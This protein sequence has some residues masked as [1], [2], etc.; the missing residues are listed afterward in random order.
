[1]IFNARTLTTLAMFVLFAGACLMA[2]QLPQ[3]AAFMPLLIGVPGTLLCA[4][5]LVIDVIRVRRDGSE[6]R[7]AETADDNSGQSETAAFLWLGLFSVALIGFGFVVGG[8]LIV[9]AFVRFS[10]RDSVP[11]A[12]FAMAGTFAVLYGVFIWLLELSLFRGLI[13]EWLWP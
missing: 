4:A 8:P 1:M 2:M 5:Q 10:S 6:F 12:L 7:A 13:I 3:K 11:T 9:G